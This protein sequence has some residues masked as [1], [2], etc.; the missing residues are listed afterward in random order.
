MV[1]A[2][3]DH[4]EGGTYVMLALLSSTETLLNWPKTT[5]TERRSAKSERIDGLAMLFWGG[6]TW[7]GRLC[8][9]KRVPFRQLR[10]DH[11]APEFLARRRGT[12]SGTE[13]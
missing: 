6:E 4:D 5:E 10:F 13:R 1:C 12:I 8:G 11:S 3:S 2:T 7:V 9:K